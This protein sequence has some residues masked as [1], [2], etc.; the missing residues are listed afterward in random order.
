MPGS[1]EVAR[2]TVNLRTRSHRIRRFRYELSGISA[3]GWIARL[4]ARSA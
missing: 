4:R 2:V 1:T 3:T